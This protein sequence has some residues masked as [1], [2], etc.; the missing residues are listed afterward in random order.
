[1]YP[2]ETRDGEFSAIIQECHELRQGG[3]DHPGKSGAGS[4]GA[5]T[6]KS[7]KKGGGKG[8]GNGG[9]KLSLGHVHRY[10]DELKCLLQ[11]PTL[12]YL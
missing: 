5:D 2:L 1:M 11:I 10:N 7:D 8:A 3:P 9:R 12:N 6:G 4:A